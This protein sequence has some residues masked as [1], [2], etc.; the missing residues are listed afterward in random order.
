MKLGKK[1]IR[2]LGISLLSLIQMVSV[3]SVVKLVWDYTNT[4]LTTDGDRTGTGWGTKAGVG[5]DE[6]RKVENQ[7]TKASVFCL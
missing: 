6:M 1:K 3:T 2:K 4:F 5:K 7:E